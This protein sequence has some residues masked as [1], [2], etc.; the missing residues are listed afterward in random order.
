MIRTIILASRFRVANT[1]I[2][3]TTKGVFRGFYYF[4]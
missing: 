1:Q 3:K 2:T 4:E